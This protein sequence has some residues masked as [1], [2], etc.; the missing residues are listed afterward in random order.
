[1]YDKIRAHLGNKYNIVGVKISKDVIDPNPPF[2]RPK[3]R[4]RFCQLVR[5]AGKGRAFVALKEDLG[6]PN[7]E[8]TLGFE[9][10]LYVDVQPRIKPAETKAIMVG[11]AEDVPNPDVLLM[12]LTAKQGME[13]AALLDGMEA[14]FKGAL[15]VCGE[16]T[17]KPYME[18]RPNLSLLCGGARMFAD[19]ADGEVIF[20]AP[21]ETY[22]EMVERVEAIEKS[23]GPRGALCGCQV[24]DI[25]PRVVTTFKKIGFERGTDYFFGKVNGQSVRVYLN[26]DFQGKLGYM[27]VHL[28]IKGDVRVKPP[29]VKSTRGK[30][31]DVSVV[32]K[33]EEIGIE[34][35]TGKGL[36]ELLEDIVSKV[37]I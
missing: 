20:G 27:T 10:P 7:A 36:V 23:C 14:R 33:L 12:I 35:N 29:F 34:L 1:M 26:K 22:K 24:T 6:C 30:W 37:K 28:P 32:V 2:E 3:K 8:V 16:A 19:Y 11:P 4:M 18:N 15:A 17:A 13:V 5:E 25:S 9:E 21:L 31:T